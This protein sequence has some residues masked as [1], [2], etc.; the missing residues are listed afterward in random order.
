MN[1]FPCFSSK[2]NRNPPCNNETNEHDDHNDFRPPGNHK[3]SFFNFPRISNMKTH[4]FLDWFD[5]VGK[6]NVVSVAATKRIEEIETEQTPLKTFN[7]R[8]LAMATKNFRQECLIGE[9]GYGRVYKGTLQSTGQ[10][11]YW[12]PQL[13][14]HFQ[15]TT[16]K[17]KERVILLLLWL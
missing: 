17:Q 15:L 9:G 8:E 10:V 3:L 1:C 6:K 12:S 16:V 4:F 11:C 2:R 14:I 5:R 7:F 13:W